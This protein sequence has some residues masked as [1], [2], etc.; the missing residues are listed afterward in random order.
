MSAAAPPPGDEAARLRAAVNRIARRLRPTKAGAG[1][2]PTQISVLETVSRRGPIRISD[3]AE[4]EDVNPTMLSRVA[5]KLEEAGLVRRHQHPGD[6]RA[7]LLSLTDKGE[8]LLERMRSERTD[9]LSV[10]LEALD[11]DAGRRLL[12]A[13]PV[14]E[15]LAES[16]KN[17][18]APASRV[19]RREIPVS[20]FRGFGR[21]AFSAL[22]IANY[23][24]YFIGQAISM[25]GTWMQTT[26]QAWLVLT[27]T[28][29]STDLGLVIALQTLPI[30]LLGPYGGVIADRV[31]KRKL[32]VVLQSL[33]GVQALVLG[34]L[35]VTGVIRL[36]EVCVLAVFLGLNNTFENPARQTF[37]LEM[38]GPE[39]LRNAV[40]LNSV[41]MNAARAVGPAVAGL[42]IATVGVGVCFLLN[43]ASFIA[44]VVSLLTLNVGLLQRT[45]PT[46][47][48]RGQ[49]REGFSYVRRNR[50]LWV[51]LIMMGMVGMLT[52]EFQVS[53]P[54]LAR[55]TFHGGSEIY[56]FMTAAMGGGAVLGG[57]FTAARG[58]TGL[59]PLIIAATGFGVVVLFAAF[60]PDARLRVRGTGARRLGQRVVPGAREL[61]AAA[62]GGPGHARPRDGAVVG[63]L[64]R[65]HPDR[66]PG[67]R[68]DHQPVRPA[69]RPGRRR[70]DLPRGRR[71][72]G[73][74][75]PLAA[76]AAAGRTRWF[77]ASSRRSRRRPAG[78][79]PSAVPR[80][81][82]GCAVGAVPEGGPVR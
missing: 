40:S 39:D 2:T 51:P 5:G 7:A 63:R 48:A 20:R 23:R 1:L 6:G 46:G 24:R 50:L 29:S 79:W 3:L 65:V 52:Y 27:L 11:G 28:N 30:L 34:L 76:R 60:A 62:G 57:L 71:L 38:V 10:E 56:G 41:L 74:H 18:D 14:L 15:A 37:V 58:R 53:L 68:L 75:R 31:D 69:R 25:V 61:D 47:R 66:R 78:R 4:V 12:E 44:V 54:V 80:S 73:A 49:L 36:W 72:R 33:M 17:R 21:D 16:L 13:L 8:R 9:Q 55:H 26:A 64:P 67:H 77:P 43:A 35:A 82:S 70:G 22:A 59:R 81:G 42:L 19:A 32:M 45:T